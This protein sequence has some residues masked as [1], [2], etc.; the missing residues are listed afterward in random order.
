MTQLSRLEQGWSC[1]PRAQSAILAAAS[2]MAAAARLNH[3]LTVELAMSGGL[4]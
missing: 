3:G 1:I 2:G 4:P